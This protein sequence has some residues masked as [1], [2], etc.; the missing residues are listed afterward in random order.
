MPFVIRT[1]RAIFNAYEIETLKRY[2]SAFER[3]MN[4]ERIPQTPAQE[5]FIKACRG[6]VKP[7][8]K[9]EK[10]WCKYLARLQ[11]ESV[12]ENRAVMDAAEWSFPIK[13]PKGFGGSREDW[14]AMRSAQWSDL[15]KRS[16]GE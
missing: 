9:Y 10:I 3:L 15:R 6:E 5:H 11:W 16:R 1:I 8:T 4:G 14:K 13:T 7:E 2:G 12:P